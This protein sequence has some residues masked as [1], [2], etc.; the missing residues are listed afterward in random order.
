MSSVFFRMSRLADAKARRMS[1]MSSVT[2][3][4][5]CFFRSCNRSS[6]M[7]LML[8]SLC[9]ARSCV[10]EVAAALIAVLLEE[11]AMRTDAHSYVTAG[12]GELKRVSMQRMYFDLSK[13]LER[14]TLRMSSRTIS[15]RL[16]VHEA[17]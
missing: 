14:T 1:I 10:Y 7:S 2:T 3:F 5:C 15:W 9:D 16:S 8:L 6:T 17:T 13:G 11:R 4:G 12:E